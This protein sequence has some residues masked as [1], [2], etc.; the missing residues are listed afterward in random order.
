MLTNSFKNPSTEGSS[1]SSELFQGLWWGSERVWLG[2]LV[3]LICSH[4]HLKLS[5][6]DTEKVDGL[7]PVEGDQNDPLFFSLEE[8]CRDPDDSQH[9]LMSGKLYEL[10]D[11]PHDADAM[12]VDSAGQLPGTDSSSSAFKVPAPPHAAESQPMPDHVFALPDPPAGKKFRLLHSP[13]VKVTLSFAVLGGRYYPALTDV[14]KRSSPD[15]QS[16]ADTLMVLAGASQQGSDENGH[17]SARGYM[18][19]DVQKGSRFEMITG[20]YPIVKRSLEK[21]WE[22]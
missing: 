17:V 10:V 13:E 21:D 6:A 4:R 20:G 8:L 1:G 12:E 7:F 15:L 14:V 2:D 5:V 22:S 19:A 11:V 3:R 16:A 18:G 9:G